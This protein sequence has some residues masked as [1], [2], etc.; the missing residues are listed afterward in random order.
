MNMPCV[1]K[2]LGKIIHWNFKGEITTEQ[3]IDTFAE[4]Y[5]D[6]RFDD[7]RG[8]VRNYREIKG[9]FTVEDVRKIAAYDRAAAKTNPYMKVA[10]V[11]TGHE[12]HSAFAALYDAELYD[13]NWEISLFTCEEEA[14]AWVG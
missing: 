1:P 4:L 10:V 2:W 6:A 8:Q 9:A 12:T 13:T 7:T 3:L 11:T 14:L 5:G